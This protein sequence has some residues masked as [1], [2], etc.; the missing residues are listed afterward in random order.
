MWVWNLAKSSLRLPSSI[1][2]L[3]AVASLSMVSSFLRCEV[4]LTQG[5][6][7]EAGPSKG[8]MPKPCVQKFQP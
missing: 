8:S 3:S 7:T 1:S 2:A 6:I 5:A 4:P